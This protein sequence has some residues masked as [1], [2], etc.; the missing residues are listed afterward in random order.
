MPKRRD[1]RDKADLSQAPIVAS[2]KPGTARRD[3]FDLREPGFG[4][5]VTPS[6]G[7]SWFV[8]FK[9]RGTSRRLVLGPF[10]ELSPIA[11]RDKAVAQLSRVREANRDPL[12]PI[13]DPALLRR[14]HREAQEA[15]RKRATLGDVAAAWLT[16]LRV[17]ASPRWARDAE[18]VVEKYVPPA[19]LRRPV[20][21]I[22]TRD[23]RAVH[24]SLAAT[25]RTA[26]V[27][28]SVLGAILT[29]AAADND[30]DPREPN[31]VQGVKP[32]KKVTRERVLGGE[33][34]DAEWGRFG[35]AW[36]T[37]RDQYAAL[38]DTR[39]AQLDC[40]LMLALTGARRDAMRLRRW[41]DLR[42]T[43]RY[44]AVSP[45]H[46]GVSRIPL[47]E[48]AL[49]YLC[50][51]RPADASPE[52]F[53]FPGQG[54][55]GEDGPAPIARVDG[56]VWRELLTA[57]NVPGFTLHDLRRTFAT[58]AAECRVSR[59]SK[60][61][62]LGHTLPGMEAIYSRAVPAKVREGA[63]VTSAEIASRLGVADLCT[64]PKTLGV[65]RLTP[66]KRAAR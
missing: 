23:V 40:V 35:S 7:R 46:K 38:R 55:R 37:L 12:S 36:R 42:E 57:A 52:D 45:S 54:R 39:A 6:G 3:V 51:I 30:R 18:R 62:I 28:R 1:A 64:P 11:A 20:A 59:V 48:A 21:E 19:L 31:P 41:A 24:E 25:P 34:D 13:E 33:D 22:T 27:V 56:P 66:R 61:A 10:P 49:E 4:V 9:F 29:R 63:D 50:R 17:Q 44:L 2:L 53:I 26:N 58:T 16:T 43:G 15:R 5:A 14:A 8:R 60:A 32:Y 65:L 47:G